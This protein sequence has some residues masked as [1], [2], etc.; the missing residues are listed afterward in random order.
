MKMYQ[1]QLYDWNCSPICDGVIRFFV[2]DLEEFE[3]NWI[4]YMKSDSE[5][6]ERYRKSKAGEMI[7]DYY[8]DDPALNIVQKKD[9]E[10]LDEKTYTETDVTKDICNVYWCASDYHI[11][12][13]TYHIRFVRNAEDGELLKLCR[14][15][16]RGICRDR[17]HSV[18]G[19]DD[20]GK[21]E[22]MG[23]EACKHLAD[24]RYFPAYHFFENGERV[25]CYTPRYGNVEVYGN[26]FINLSSTD[27][28]YSDYLEKYG[29]FYSDHLE[30][31]KNVT[32]ELFVWHVVKHFENEKELED[33][34]KNY[35][36]DEWETQKLLMDFPG[37]AG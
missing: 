19:W 2:D 24:E 35:R 8:S 37:E 25:A 29:A 18:W 14:Y 4:P 1:I 34:I 16:I 11:D 36:L 30:D 33:N 27:A 6:V 15:E 28:T 32:A 13:I 20:T 23:F 31:F 10:I 26:P 5:T 9:I 22:K 7:T 17:G 12:Q 21:Y 3:K